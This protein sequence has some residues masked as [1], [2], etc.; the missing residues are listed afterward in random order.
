VPVTADPPPEQNDAV[1]TD[2]DSPAAQESSSETGAPADAPALRCTS[3]TK[4]FGERVAVDDVS[5]TIARGESYGLLGPN[6]AGK[7]TTINLL[8]GLLKADE[9]TVDIGGRPLQSDPRVKAGIGY[10]PQEIA[11]YPDLSGR[12][13][14]RFF[15][16]LYGLQGPALNDR[17]ADVLD[18]AGLT[19]RADDRVDAYSGGMKRRLNI[20][21]GLL[22]EPALLVLDEPTVGVDPQSRNAILEHVAQLRHEGLA[23]LYTS[24]YMEEVEKLCDRVGIIDDGALI[25]EGTTDELVAQ[26]GETDRITLT[27]DGDPTALVGAVSEVFGV[28][29]VSQTATGVQLLAQDGPRRLPALLAAA[30]G[31]G[32]SVTNVDV[33]RPNLESVFLHLTG[34]AL[35]D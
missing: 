8:C 28:D 21:A 5:F 19:E 29:K 33:V 14:L 23:V 10:V 18:T 26:L 30:A 7:T 17:I 15:G 24:H 34:K 3:L 27:V 12:E 16:R 4:R 22:H 1:E 6:G 9:G 20:A 35:R 31:Q 11:L 25:A 2:D 32:V 13:N